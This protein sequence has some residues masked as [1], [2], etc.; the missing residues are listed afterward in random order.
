MSNHFVSEEI[1]DTIREL[2]DHYTELAKGCES[3]EIFET[4]VE[5]SSTLR[6]VARTIATVCPQNAFY[7]INLLDSAVLAG[8]Q[9]RLRARKLIR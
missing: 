1:A 4:S 7:L 9:D 3:P 2:A 8:L 5:L 6:M